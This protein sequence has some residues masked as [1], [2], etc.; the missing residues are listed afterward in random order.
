MFRQFFPLVVALTLCAVCLPVRPACAA[1]GVS[2]DGTLKYPAEFS[3]FAYVDPAARQGGS[4]TLHDLGSFDKMNPFTLKGNGPAGLT[5]YVFETLAVPSLDE[6][7]AEYGLIAEEIALAPDRKSVT[8]TLNP[9]ARFSDGTPITAEDIKFSL[10][11]LKSDQ[12]HPFYQIYFRDIDGADILGERQVRFRFARTN[13]ELHMIATQLPVLSRKFYTQHPFNPA[14]GDGAMTVPV[15]SGPYTVSAVVPGKSITYT[16]NPAYWAAD[17]PTRRHQFNFDTITFKYFKDPVVSLE[18]FK[19]GEFDFMMV[20]IAKQWQRDLTGRRFDSGELVKKTFPHHNNAGMQA[21]VFNTRRPLFQDPLVRRA[22]GLA[23]DFEWTNRTLFFSQYTRNDSFF[24]NSDYAAR[25]LPD[26]A[27]LR[28]LEPLR[29]QV[30]AEVFTRPLVPPSTEPPNSLRANML[31]AKTLLEQAGWTVRG[32]VLT[33]AAGETFTFDILL[34]DSSFQRVIAPYAANL[35]KLGI[36]V[37]YRTIDPAL[38]ADRVRDFD[39][40]MVVTSFGQSQSPGNEQRDYWTSQAADRKGSRNLAG[41]HSPA[42]DALVDAVIYADTQEQLTTACRA[43]DR[44][45][46]HGYYLVPNWYLANHRLAFT[47]RLRYPST[48]PL[49]YSHEQWLDTWWLAKP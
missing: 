45:L 44:V 9:R 18:A 39:F 42:V 37:D 16:K 28:L 2:I 41:I 6:P 22:L 38:Y 43:L 7:F 36:A 4:L 3:R 17:H 23:F 31:E 27:E 46:W 24:A 32:G 15:G 8:F 49:Y 33:N 25:G 20:H 13:R 5:R 26:A 1:H 19:A 47:S 10:E 48:L 21:F 40:D 30:P 29:A 11:T 34:V 14:G 35:R 12:A